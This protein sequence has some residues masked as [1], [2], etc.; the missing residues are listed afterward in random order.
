MQ[1]GSEFEFENLYSS[2]ALDE[3]QVLKFIARNPGTWGN[4]IEV[5][6][7]NPEDFGLQKNVFPGIDLD[8]LYEYFPDAAENEVGVIIKYQG[9]IKEVFLVSLDKDSRDSNNKSNYIENVLNRQSNIVYVK[10]VGLA[11]DGIATCLNDE[12]VTLEG[13]TYEDVTEGDILTAYEV[14]EN[15]EEVD[16]DIVIGNELDDGN[17]AFNLAD[18]RKDCIAFIGTQYNIVGKKA[19][20][21][22]A[23]VI[24]NRGDRNSMFA[25]YASNYKFQYDRYNDKNRWVNLAGDIA[26]LRA[27]TSS[28]RASWWASAGLE[29]GQIKNA[30]K[31][32][33][34][35]N[36]QQRD[37]LYKKNINPVVTFPGQ[38]TV[39]WGQK[40]LLSKPSSFD[41]VNVRGLFN[42]L[43]RSLAKMAKYQVMEFNDNFTRN[44]I[45]SMIKPFLGTVQ[46][47]RGI[48][49]FMIICDSSNNTPDVISRNQLIVDC[50]IKPTYAAEFIL[51]RFTNA[52]TN[53][54]SE[55]VG[56]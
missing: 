54:F 8:G 21:A 25:C 7:A 52:G 22:N 17:A 29:R 15:K 32:A 36:Q 6:I 4:Q 40:T 13:G 50:Y 1:I 49:D 34:N 51:L 42:T 9:E 48:E 14:W 43:E 20:D 26:G 19:A 18:G 38:G 31:L 2:I 35:P 23:Q 45:V 24:T 3:G 27:Q 16:I 10:Y 41:R 33:Y 55:I 47:G 30:I 12:V 5:A 11:E 28:A 39:M 53:N 44:R 46:A 56:G 37:A